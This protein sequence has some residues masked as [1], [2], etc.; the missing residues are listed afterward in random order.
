MITIAEAYQA[1]V[2]F[3]EEQ[4]RR[5]RFLPPTQEEVHVQVSQQTEG[6]PEGQRQTTMGGAV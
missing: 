3:E 2:E 4:Y 6:S 1:Q 5:E